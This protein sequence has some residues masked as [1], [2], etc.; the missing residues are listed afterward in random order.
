MG[1]ED[2]VRLTAGEEGGE[3]VVAEAAGCFFK[4]LGVAGGAGF[5]ESSGDAG[6][7][8]VKGD[9]E[10]G[11]EVFDETL[12]GVGFFAAQAMVDVDGGEA[13][14]EGFVRGGVGGVEGEE[15]GN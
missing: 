9:V 15:E 14:A 7:V 6:L 12:V 1:G 4:G 5:C 3:V 2:A 8:E 13:D 10:V 11:A